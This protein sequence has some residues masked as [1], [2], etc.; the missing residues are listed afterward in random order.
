MVVAAAVPTPPGVVAAHL[1]AALIGVANHL[2]AGH[3]AL[4]E[5]SAAA[6]P[7]THE[8]AG[9]KAGRGALGTG[10][11]AAE[12]LAHYQVWGCTGPEGLNADNMCV[13]ERGGAAVYSSRRKTGCSSC[14]QMACHEVCT[15]RL[16]RVAMQRVL[17]SAESAAGS[18]FSRA[19]QLAA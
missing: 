18:W 8:A 15:A 9:V 12:G 19:L 10:A 7:T 6:H 2:A 13:R 16:T 1:L 3:P 11:G 4:Y 5:D 14:Q 17:A